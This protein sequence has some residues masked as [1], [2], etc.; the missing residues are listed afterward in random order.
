MGS[1]PRRRLAPIKEDLTTE[2]VQRLKRSRTRLPIRQES[3]DQSSLWRLPNTTSWRLWLPLAL[4]ASA[5]IANAGGVAADSE[6]GKNKAGGCAAC[7]GE[8]GI[9]LTENTP[10]L[11][12]QP[13]QFLQ[14]QLVFFRSG[15]RKNEIMEPA[16][17]QLSN[18]DV[19]DL[20][21]YFASLKP[22]K[23]SSAE[24]TDDRPELTEAGKMTAAIG[25]CA[26]CHGDSFAGSKAVAR[27]AGQRED[28][29]AK[30][31]HDYKA[32]RRGWWCRRDGGSG[33]PA[34]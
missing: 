6:A 21:A 17:E 20:A 19:R 13:D 4:A 18:E 26:S 25:R 3:N 15:A 2:S 14:W 9:S 32:G 1:H 31:L 10:S 22:P 34:E 23:S 5:L 12:A 7:H 11:A 27:I 29:I 33:L 24:A 8:N 30:A 16:A 28:Y